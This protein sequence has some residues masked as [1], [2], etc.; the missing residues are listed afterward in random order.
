MYEQL[1]KLE[2]YE[3][4]KK[5]INWDRI[6]EIRH[7]KERMVRKCQKMAKAALPKS[8]SLFQTYIAPED[9]RVKEMEKWFRDQQKRADASALRRAEAHTAQPAS[10]HNHIHSQCPHCIAGSPST[11]PPAILPPNTSA[12][13][14]PPATSN[15]QR[16]A[17]NAVTNLKAPSKPGFYSGAHALVNISRAIKAERTTSLPVNQ[18]QTTP[19][20]RASVVSPPPLPVL[21]RGQRLQFGLDDE[22][23]QEESALGDPE[24]P[25]SSSGGTPPPLES[26]DIPTDTTIQAPQTSPLSSGDETSSPDPSGTVRRRRSCIK[27]GSFSEIGAKTVSWADDHE[28]GN[29]V[30]RFASAARDAQASGKKTSP[31]FISFG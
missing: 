16:A 24:L 3:L 29:Q 22:P 23:G 13:L 7:L 15:L 17:T 26:R 6:V 2:S 20:T 31:L 11:H 21:L 19:S 1:L 4:T 12:S 9:F 30:S 25:E 28:L 8:L 18:E 10:N 27:R 5:S 14:V